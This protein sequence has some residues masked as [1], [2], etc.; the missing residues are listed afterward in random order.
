MALVIVT[1]IRFMGRFLLKAILLQNLAA[2][3]QKFIVDIIF[4]SKIFRCS[5]AAKKADIF[6]YPYIYIQ[7]LYIIYIKYMYIYIFYS[8]IYY[9]RYYIY[10]SFYF[11]FF[12]TVIPFMS[13]RSKIVGCRSMQ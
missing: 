5:A 10:Y 11:Y 13:C 6:D 4:S 8:L 2:L 9:I 3:Q 7:M 12:S 1:C